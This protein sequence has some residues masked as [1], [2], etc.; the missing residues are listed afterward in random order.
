MELLKNNQNNHYIFIIIFLE[1]FISIG[2]ELLAIRTTIPYIGSNIVN[3]S[4]IIGIFLLFLSLGYYYGGT[5][6][7]KFEE[8]LLQNLTKAAFIFVIGTN[9]IFLDTFFL[10]LFKNVN[11]IFSLMIY[12]LIIIGPIIFLLGQ[13]IPIVINFLNIDN[14]SK[15]NSIVL[16]LSTLGSFLGSIL[17]TLLLFNFFGVDYTIFI[18][19]FVFVLLICL[20]LFLLWNQKI[21]KQTIYIARYIFGSIFIIYISFT[22]IIIN[23]YIYQNNYSSTQIME[24]NSIKY[25]II[26]NSLSASF[27]KETNNSEFDYI[28]FIQNE[29][30][31]NSKYNNH[32][33]NI[34]IIGSGGFTISLPDTKNN[35]TY[36]DIDKNLKEEVEKHFLKSQI[37]HN[38][39]GEDIRKYLL[40]TK[41]KYDIIVMDV[42]NNN[43]TIP[44]YLITKEFFENINKHIKDDGKIYLNIISNLNSKYA[45]HINQTINKT[46]NCYSFVLHY[47]NYSITIPNKDYNIIYN[48]NKNDNIIYTDNLTNILET[49]NFLK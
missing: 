13:T 9:V 39:I 18:F 44:Q 45:N 2:I 3:T 4:I 11:P 28:K 14:I 30:Q 22:N 34:L 5:I 15:T 6:K 48:C 47:D 32:G 16:F 37:N 43:H 24:H 42:Y 19:A 36:I 10:M 1:G 25:L 31:N 8:K 7:D 20:I 38:F 12:N 23:K 17:T 29:I 49:N 40:Y 41:E 21:I 33:L 26:N 46:L 35:Y 27:N